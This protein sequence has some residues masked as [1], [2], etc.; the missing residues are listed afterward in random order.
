MQNQ[1]QQKEYIC[2]LALPIDFLERLPF[3]HE[4]LKKINQLQSTQNN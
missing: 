1:Y 3:F 2:R 4:N